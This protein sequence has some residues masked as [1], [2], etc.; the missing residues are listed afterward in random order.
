MINKKE[1]SHPSL[2]TQF[3]ALLK[4]TIEFKS[5]IW[6][7]QITDGQF[8]DESLIINE[9]TFN[10]PMQWMKQHLYSE[11]MISKVDNLRR[12]EIIFLQLLDIEHRIMRV[13]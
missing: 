7:I 4:K 10:E 12:S 2:F 13:K 11:E 6:V 8:K 3:L 5:R 9:D 1:H